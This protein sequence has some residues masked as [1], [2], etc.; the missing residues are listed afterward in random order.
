MLLWMSVK[1]IM[2]PKTILTYLQ[3]QGAM[4]QAACNGSHQCGKCKIKITNRSVP[5]NPKEARM[6]TTKEIEEGYRLACFHNYH[7]NDTIEIE[8]FHG[9]ILEKTRDDLE[10]ES[11]WLEEGYGIVVD[12]GTTTVVMQWIDVIT[13]QVV[14]TESFYNPQASYGSD[15]IR[16]IDY[17]SQDNG[18]ILHDILVQRMEKALLHCPV[19]TIKQMVVTGN[20]TMIHIFLKHKTTALGK[21]PFTMI[22]AKATK[23]VSTHWFPQYPEVFE[24]FTLP[25]ISAFVGSDIVCGIVAS[26]IHKEEKIQM[27]IDLGTNGELAVGNKEKIIVT[28]TAAGPAF[29][30]VSMECGGPSYDGAIYKV[31]IDK[32]GIT[33]QTIGNKEATCICG[34]GYVS[35]I[36]ALLR[37]GYIDE[38]GRFKE[39]R[40]RFYLSDTLYIS[41][42]DIQAFQLAKAAIQT[43]ITLL[44]KEVKNID[45]IYIAG[46]FGEHIAIEDLITLQMI[47]EKYLDK[48]C[49]IKNGALMGAK[50]ALLTKDMQE[51]QMV[52]TKTKSLNLAK[53]PDFND[54]LIESLYFYD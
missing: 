20:T 34:S 11:R 8:T 9:A 39:Q 54:T 47:D 7:P 28:A 33:Y 23:N 53:H 52:V 51:F 18:Y 40:T 26:N 30:G 49:N 38:M 2:S 16:R 6:L 44:S 48:V 42:K 4:V 14:Y 32:Q 13:K 22:E 15:V 12:I 43:G 45:R 10:I 37:L 41:N 1:N 46:G 3:E 21:S 25:H 31:E 24:V 50:I 5:I 27:L 35:L 29:E 19:R 36:S 17:D